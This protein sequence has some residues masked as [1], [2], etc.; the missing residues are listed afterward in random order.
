M[1]ARSRSEAGGEGAE[2]SANLYAENDDPGGDVVIVGDSLLAAGPSLAIDLA[3]LRFMSVNQVPNGALSVIAEDGRLVFAK[4]YTLRAA[5]TAAGEPA[6]IAG[7]NSKFRIGSVSKTLTAAGILLLRQNGMLPDD[8]ATLA[9]RFV[10]FTAVPPP[11]RGPW[12]VDHRL[13]DI[14]LLHLLTHTAGWFEGEPEEDI[15]VTTHVVLKTCPK[16]EW[17]DAASI[18][19]VIDTGPADAFDQ[20][21]AAFGTTLPVTHDQIL[22]YGNTLPLSVAPGDRYH[23]SNWSYWLLARVIEGA[24]CRRY[25]SFIFDELLKPLGMLDTQVGRTERSQRAIGEVPYFVQAWPSD[26]G[27]W[28]QVCTQSSPFEIGPLDYVPYAERDLQAADGGGGWISSVFDLA[29]LNAQLFAA[30]GSALASSSV[31]RMIR[32]WACRDAAGN[33]TGLGL[34]QSGSAV[35]KG[36]QFNGCL[37]RIEYRGQGTNSYSYAYA[38]NRNFSAFDPTGDQDKMRDAIHSALNPLNGS[39]DWGTEDLFVP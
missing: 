15:S 35:R 20:I 37:A 9:G 19:N 26:P 39:S 12:T 24:T 27:A 5:Y 8:L 18:L 17:A 31:A 34:E 2:C 10:D 3:V 28:I 32:A 22:R 38:F 16:V 11:F 6:F 21:T 25:E 29:L 36:G 4:G 30:R 13:A 1:Q 33:T 7:P 23:Y 14:S